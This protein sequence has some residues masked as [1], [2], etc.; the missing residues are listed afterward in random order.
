MYGVSIARIR[1][2]KEFQQTSLRK[3]KQMEA[4]V[5]NFVAFGP[6]RVVIIMCNEDELES[7]QPNK[8]GGVAIVSV[9][10]YGVLIEPTI[11]CMRFPITFRDILYTNVIG[12]NVKIHFRKDFFFIRWTL[13]FN[14][15]QR[16]EFLAL[17]LPSINL[18][19]DESNTTKE[20]K[21]ES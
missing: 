7:D 4:A 6:M 11:D 8:W 10:R 1:E 14:E 18:R 20:R 16:N 15:S 12:N 17:L 2:F 9:G 13:Y 5:Q 19:S 3:R 21:Q